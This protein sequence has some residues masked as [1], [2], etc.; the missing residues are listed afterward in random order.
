MLSL[1]RS[2]ISASGSN[3]SVTVT[4]KINVASE[5]YLKQLKDLNGDQT[6]IAE[7]IKE[8]YERVVQILPYIIRLVM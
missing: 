3:E 1:S 8:Q 7:F 6:K 4:E 2:R 5:S